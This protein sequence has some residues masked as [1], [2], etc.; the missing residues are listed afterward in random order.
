[1]TDSGGRWKP[2][3]GRDKYPC[4]DCA[5]RAPGC[6]DRCERFKAA[7]KTNE[8][9]KSIEREKRGTDYGVTNIQYMG[10]LQVTRGK[11]PER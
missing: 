7:K 9:R 2:W 3:S 6:H 4:K 11:K 10:F 1:M 8:N 5:Q